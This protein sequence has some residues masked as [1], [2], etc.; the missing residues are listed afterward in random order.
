M[1]DTVDLLLYERTLADKRR[2]QIDLSRHYGQCMHKLVSRWAARLSSH[3]FAILAFV[4]DR[5]VFH[6]KLSETVVF[7]QFLHGMRRNDRDEMVFCGLN[8]SLPTLLK[9]LKEL[10]DEGF[11]HVLACVGPNGRAEIRPRLY[12]INCKK[13]F[14]LDIAD[15][16]NPMILRMPREKKQ[17]SSMDSEENDVDN[18]SKTVRKLLKTREKVGQTPSKKPPQNFEG[19]Y[20]N[21]ISTKVDIVGGAALAEPGRKVSVDS[22]METL[23]ATRLAARADRIGSTPTRRSTKSAASRSPLSQANMQELFDTA[24][25]TYHP[26][27][28]RT[29]VT[30]KELGVFKKR[31]ALAEVE[32]EPFVHWAIQFWLTIATGH[33]RGARRRAGEGDGYRYSPMAQAPDFKDLSYRFNYFLSAYRSHLNAKAHGLA[34]TRE[35]QLVQ[36]VEKLE[37]ALVGAKDEARSANE[38]TRSAMRRNAPARSAAPAEE[39]AA[40]TN[41]RARRVPPT[42]RVSADLDDLPP[43]WEDHAEPVKA[44]K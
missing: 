43:A 1:L 12:A 10:S 6:N 34:A 2:G 28:P 40:P 5:T 9:Q 15:E 13:L 44:R 16:E 38:R 17:T 18:T 24:M 25:R 8:I 30:T 4:L 35:E 22:A 23:R 41:T 37:R 26:T 33:E 31:L 20:T 36:K 19:I 29:V 39:P 3:Q 32:L 27:L 21:H 7:D 11:L 42:R 14:N